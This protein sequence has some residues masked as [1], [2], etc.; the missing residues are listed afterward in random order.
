MNVQYELEKLIEKLI[1]E[2]EHE[3]HLK[4]KLSEEIKRLQKDIVGLEK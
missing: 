4:R 3:R 1:K 2:L